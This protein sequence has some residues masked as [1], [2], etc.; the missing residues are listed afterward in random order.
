MEKIGKYRVGEVG[1][2]E[3]DA[4]TSR[5]SIPFLK[6]EYKKSYKVRIISKPYRYY[7]HWINTPNGKRKVNCALEDCPACGDEGPKLNRYVKGLL[8]SDNGKSE[9]V[10]L[11]IGSQIYKQLKQLNESSSWGALQDYDITISKGAKGAN[12]LY[13]VQPE[14]KTPL[15]DEEKNLA[16]KV[17]K[18]EIDDKENPDYID[19]E[20]MCQPWTIDRIKKSQTGED[21]SDNSKEKK[22]EGASD[23]EIFDDEPSDTKEETKKESA[24]V[25]ESDEDDDDFLDL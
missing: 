22:E 16:K 20:R 10:V 17:N 7:L 18:K 14:P 1:W 2:D 6:M 25:E 4:P 23:N 13:T 21:F 11:D 5:A 24:K 9:V 12:P 8:K 15:T 19:L 3:D